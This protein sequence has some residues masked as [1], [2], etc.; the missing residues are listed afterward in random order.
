MLQNIKWL[1][2]DSFLIKKGKIIC[3][4]PYKLRETKDKADIILI[5]HD[6]FDHFS[7]ED[8][9]KIKKDSTI[10]IGPKE[11]IGKY[12]GELKTLKPFESI[13]VDGIKINTIPAYNV[14]KFRAP[15]KVFHPK[16]DNKLGFVITI[17]NKKIYHAGDTDLIQEMA[18]L[19]NIEIALLPVSGTYVM[20]AEEASQAVDIIQPKIAI[21]M[22]FNSVVGN[23]KDALKFK[24]LVGDKCLVEILKEE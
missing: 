5:T 2:H 20:T 1:G 10:L 4:D 21:P 7:L 15:G 14:N 18:Q 11:L 9:E 24:R 3:I 16:K 23:E 12:D 22:H 17:D 8:I 13:D 19:R 6:H